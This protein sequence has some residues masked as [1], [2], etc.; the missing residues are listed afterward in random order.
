MELNQY[1]LFQGVLYKRGG[2]GIMKVSW[3]QRW[4][5]L[6]SIQH[7]LRYYDHKND[8]QLKGVIDLSE[9]RP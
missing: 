1:L 4:F 9:V 7:Q 2:I 8:P 3:K 6:D 5:V